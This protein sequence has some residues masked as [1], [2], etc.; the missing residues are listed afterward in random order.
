VRASGWDWWYCRGSP[1]IAIG[2]GWLT[3]GRARI[4]VGLLGPA[5]TLDAAAMRLARGTGLNA[6]AYLCLRGWL[7]EGVQV[8]VLD[9]ADPTPYWLMSSR[10]P[11]ALAT[12][13]SAAQA[14]ARAGSAASGEPHPQAGP[15]SG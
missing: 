2:D 8:P 1:V 4:P 11:G 6:R 3:A 12:A 10:R 9:P 15:D 5:L 13:L 14:A 7:A